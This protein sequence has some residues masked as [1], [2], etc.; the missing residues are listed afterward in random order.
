MSIIDSL[1]GFRFGWHCRVLI[2][3]GDLTD[4]PSIDLSDMQAFAALNDIT[5]L[6]AGARQ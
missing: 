6:E 2:S 3:A 5:L 1:V 4:L